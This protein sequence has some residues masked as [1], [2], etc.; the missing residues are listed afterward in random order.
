MVWGFVMRKDNNSG[1]II[2]KKWNQIFEKYNILDEINSNGYYSI[3][4]NQ[5]N[6]FKEARLMTKFDHRDNLP[7]LFYNNNLSIL[8]TTRGRY[9]I[10]QYDAYKKLSYNKKI[11]TKRISFPSWIETVD[12]M[13]LYSEAAVISCA[14][15]SGIIQDV[16]EEEIGTVI[17]PTVSGRMSTKS[18]DFKIKSSINN[19]FHNIS[20]QNSQCEIDGGYES[21][22]KL[23]LLEAKN[24]ASSDFLIRQLYYPYRLWS[25]KITKEVV[26]VFLTYSND[27]FSFFIYEFSDPN[28][29]NSIKL[30][31]QKN[32]IIDDAEEITF[33]DIDDLLDKVKCCEEPNYPFPQADTF[34]RVI[35]LINVLATK[36]EYTIEEIT[37]LYSFDSRQAQYYSRA[38]MYLGLIEDMGKGRVKL[39]SVAKKI[40]KM[41]TK[42][43]NLAIVEK[44]LQHYVFNEA[45]RV[46]FTEYRPPTS[47]EIFVIMKNSNIRNIDSENTLRRRAQT[48]SKWIEWIVALVHE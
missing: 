22:N 45:L 48:V 12:Y 44:I 32:Y 36:E 13:N 31:K 27:I 16:M 39:T 3:T 19:N 24:C 8:P 41:R 21:L 28:N 7:D 38:G 1:R 26:P 47:N 43:K 42:E 5:I 9:L 4:A 17:L 15:A 25:N 23:I 30:I 34:S 11:E 10:G 35:D 46:Y 29:Y 6:E 20:V 40:M 18:F 2:D 33:N 37:I 14:F